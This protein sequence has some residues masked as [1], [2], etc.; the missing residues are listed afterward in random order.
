MRRLP[1][2]VGE[3]EIVKGVTVQTMER[4][5]ESEDTLRS[6][7]VVPSSGLESMDAATKR[8]ENISFITNAVA[9]TLG[10]SVTSITQ[11]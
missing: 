3:N 4:V 6:D 1:E 7:G 8:E 2:V 9:H 5:I 10:Y 11:N